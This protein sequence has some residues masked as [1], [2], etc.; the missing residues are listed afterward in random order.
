MNN[1]MLKNLQ[2]YWVQYMKLKNFIKFSTFL[3]CISSILTAHS[4]EYKT[5]GQFH[6]APSIMNISHENIYRMQSAP[7][8]GVKIPMSCEPSPCDPSKRYAVFFC[9]AFPKSI[10]D[11]SN[12]L[13]KTFDIIKHADFNTANVKDIKDFLRLMIYCLE[14]FID[15]D[16]D[17]IK[18]LQGHL[19]KLS[20]FNK[21]TTTSTSKEFQNFIFQN[22]LCYKN[23]AE[24]I[25]LSIQDV[26]CLEKS[27]EENVTL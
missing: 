27:H 20:L 11:I 14:E 7:I 18:V 13:T 2:F 10:E 8:F 22:Q 24:S 4:F 25:A 9:T 21:K 15:K 12:H 1:I 19:L 23:I 16:S 17:I 6:Y 5:I 3:G 26:S